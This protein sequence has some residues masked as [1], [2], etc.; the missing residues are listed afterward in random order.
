MLSKF[1]HFSINQHNLRLVDFWARRLLEHSKV[2]RDIS[3][4]ELV[5]E[6][7]LGLTKAAENF[8]GRGSFI[9]YAQPFVRGQL[10]R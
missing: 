6:G 5:T 7:V 2:A 10:Y 1:I 3:Y 8:D 9:R 4:Y